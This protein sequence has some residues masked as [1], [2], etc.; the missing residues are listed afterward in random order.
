MDK[1]SP[2][3]LTARPEQYVFLG[4]PVEGLRRLAGQVRGMTPADV[5]SL[6]GKTIPIALDAINYPETGS[7]PNHHDDKGNSMHF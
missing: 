4:N 7:R 3:V 1:D 2:G 5:K 6:G